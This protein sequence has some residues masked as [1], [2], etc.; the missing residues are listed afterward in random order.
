MSTDWKDRAIHRYLSGCRT[1]QYPQAVLVL[2]PPGS[3]KGTVSEELCHAFVPLGQCVVVD[4]HELACLHPDYHRACQSADQPAL[5]L[6]RDAA[7][8]LATTMLSLAA[9]Q[10]KNVVLDDGIE[11]PERLAGVVAELKAG[12]H[13][14][15][16]VVLCADPAQSWRNCQAREAWQAEHTGWARRVEKQLHDAAC[17]QL[18]EFLNLLE[19]DGRV[20]RILLVSGDGRTVAEFDRQTGFTPG[21]CARELQVIQHA[22]SSSLTAP[23]AAVMANANA[24]AILIGGLSIRL[25]HSIAGGSEPRPCQPSVLSTAVPRSPVSAS[26]SVEGQEMLPARFA[27]PLKGPVRT[28]PQ[29]RE[30]RALRTRILQMVGRE[31]RPED[32]A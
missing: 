24:G 16:A 31:P 28:D 19:S 8:E 29:L 9:R 14:I 4:P 3:G 13:E 18:G 23:P 15:T 30:R 10:G 17:S 7:G 27:T 20:D 22:S 6:I 32:V 1:C 5:G 25:G 26:H 21:Q 12:G 11:D 2:G